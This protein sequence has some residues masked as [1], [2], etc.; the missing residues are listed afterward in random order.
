[1]AFLTDLFNAKATPAVLDFIHVD[2]NG[3]AV[4]LSTCEKKIHIYVYVNLNTDM[5]HSVL[6]AVLKFK[7]VIVLTPCTYHTAKMT[8]ILR[9]VA[10]FKL[11]RSQSTRVI[12]LSQS[13]EPAAEY[14][15]NT[16]NIRCFCGF[17]TE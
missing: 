9:F 6:G 1:M 8:H 15:R 7:C 13:G 3:G 14:D 5:N 2:Y 10:S 17:Q 11:L 16:F 12:Y 4:K